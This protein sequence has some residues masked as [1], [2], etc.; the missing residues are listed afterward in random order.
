MLRL[1][2]LTCTEQGSTSIGDAVKREITQGLVEGHGADKGIAV[3]DTC[4]FFDFET[5]EE[6]VLSSSGLK[7]VDIAP[8]CENLGR[9]KRLKKINLKG[10]ELSDDCGYAIAEGLKSNFADVANVAGR[11]AGAVTAA[12]FLQRF[13]DKFAWA[14]LDIAG[15]AWKGGAQKGATGRPVGLLV[16]YLLGPAQA[17]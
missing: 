1:F 10:N 14:H 7:D 2:V 17:K 12:K 15:S 16:E 3:A 11:A 5:C 8:L 6:I 4:K 13:A 9:F